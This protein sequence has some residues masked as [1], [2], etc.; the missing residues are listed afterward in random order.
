MFECLCAHCLQHTLRNR[1]QDI[2][3]HQ[4]GAAWCLVLKM[5]FP[6]KEHPPQPPCILTEIKIVFV[7][8]EQCYLLD[9]AALCDRGRE[10]VAQKKK[11]IE[12]SIT[13]CL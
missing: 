9:R 7:F 4:H 13:V 3:A 6:N 2:D 12:K 8:E 5:L 11:E 10:T 1:H